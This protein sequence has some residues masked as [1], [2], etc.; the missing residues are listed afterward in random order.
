MDVAVHPADKIPRLVV[1]DGERVYMYRIA[2]EK[3]DAEWS[4]SARAM[5][6]VLTIQLVDLNG[7]GTFEVVGTRWHPDS[8]LN[9]FILEFKGGKPRFLI[10]DSGLF[11]VAMDTTASYKRS[12][13][14][15]TS[16]R[17]FFNH[18]TADLT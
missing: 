15:Q 1:S 12:L 2:G 5:G 4:I 6:Q 3:L 17:K 16:T 14:A 8:G 11:L 9:S 7:D 13:W 10:E 18:G